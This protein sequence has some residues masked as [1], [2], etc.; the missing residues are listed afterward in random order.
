MATISINSKAFTVMVIF[1]VQPDDQQEILNHCMEVAS[2]FAE[3]PGFLSQNIHR[4]LDGSQIIN[5]LQWKSRQYHE[6]CMEIQEMHEPA[7]RLRDLIAQGKCLMDVQA[8][9]V[10]FSQES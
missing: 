7:K 9:E 5:Y 6:N 3:Q 10:V 8:Y 2:I 4:S 1:S